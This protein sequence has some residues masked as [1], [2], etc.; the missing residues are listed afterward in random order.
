VGIGRSGLARLLVGVGFF[1]V[2]IGNLAWV[3]L[4]SPSPSSED[5]FWIGTAVG[6]VLL[7][8]AFWAWLK[9]LSATEN[10]DPRM[11]MVLRLFAIACLVLGVAYLGL[12][13]ELLQLHRKGF[14]AGLRRQ[15]VSY[16]LSLGGFCGAAVGFWMASVMHQSRDAQI[17]QEVVEPTRSGMGH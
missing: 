16:A 14:H 11:R 1:L 12:V 10:A 3:G 4:D 15:A 6:F 9:T 8:V 5:F 7:G 13:N 17:K 2:G